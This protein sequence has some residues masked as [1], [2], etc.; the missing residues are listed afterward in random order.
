MKTLQDSDALITYRIGP[1]YCCS[2]T[3]AV[4]AVM[5]PPKLNHPPGSEPGVF[6]YSS[7]MVKVVDLRSRFGLPA[8]HWHQPGKIIVV[9]I[10]T[11]RAGFWVDEILDV[12]EFP[13]QGWKSLDALM[14]RE[15]FSRVLVLNDIIHLYADFEKLNDFHGTGYLREYIEKLIKKEVEVKENKPDTSKNLFIETKKI[16]DE[17]VI[18]KPSNKE[19]NAVVS[20]DLAILNVPEVKNIS[21][22]EI[23]E[24]ITE[25]KDKKSSQTFSP[26]SKTPPAETSVEIKT[27]HKISKSSANNNVQQE[28][29][30]G[31]GKGEVIKQGVSI[32]AKKTDPQKT[33]NNS[34]HQYNQPAN[35]K[36][37]LALLWVIIFVLLIVG[38]IAGLDVKGLMTSQKV[39]HDVLLN[40]KPLADNKK[41][42]NTPVVEK[43]KPLVAMVQI[44][45]KDNN[46]NVP[47]KKIVENNI[48]KVKPLVNYQAKIEKDDLGITIILSDDPVVTESQKTKQ[49]KIIP[50]KIIPEKNLQPNDKN[51]YQTIKDN[52]QHK[53]TA[54]AVMIHA[55]N[56]EPK[57]KLKDE[58]PSSNISKTTQLKKQ[59]IVVHIVVKGDTLW[60]IAKRYVKNPFKYMELAR[61]SKIKNPDLIY[62]GDRVTIIRILS[63]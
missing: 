2:P 39:T 13:Q 26:L 8:E 58:H 4:E 44:K 53:L 5:M 34:H 11:G 37:S 61:L 31:K 20:V 63:Q 22:K 15:V 51:K 62:P 52:T 14:P 46:L 60:D 23:P 54:K 48:K 40:Q 7:G 27:Q 10:E 30:V 42:L 49:Q 57:T 1:V 21:L 45:E 33:N 50:E 43:T 24:K 55:D 18:K 6:K 38:L 28:N 41:R 19:S 35:K 59:V 56:V 16:D 3:L 25:S 32:S 9:E 12:I 17:T 29:I 36:Q 47:P